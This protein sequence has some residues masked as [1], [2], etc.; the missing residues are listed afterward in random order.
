MKFIDNSCVVPFGLCFAFVTVTQ[1]K[2]IN[3]L[4]FSTSP[5]HNFTYKSIS[6]SRYRLVFCVELCTNPMRTAIWREESLFI[7]NSGGSRI[8]PDLENLYVK[9]KES[10][11]FGV[12]SAPSGPANRRIKRGLFWK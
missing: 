8:P 5:S 7:G 10:G 2:K 3:V 1:E 6:N 4:M 12:W 9:T 11:C